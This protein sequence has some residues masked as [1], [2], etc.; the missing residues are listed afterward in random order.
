MRK[1]YDLTSPELAT[2]DDV[3]RLFTSYAR[4]LEDLAA[5]GMD[6][7]KGQF[8]NPMQFSSIMRLVTEERSNL[9]KEM[10]MFKRFDV[11]N[12]ASI[13]E[14]EFIEGWYKLSKDEG[15]GD[16]LFNIKKLVGDNN[17]LL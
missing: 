10:Q 15:H 14:A 17:I 6:I 5:S 9:F 12:N 3:R 2:E 8:L 1:A 16:Y 13:N 4:S 7:S 11:N